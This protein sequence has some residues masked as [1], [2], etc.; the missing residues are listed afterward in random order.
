LR[1]A[2]DYFE[3]L[4]RAYKCGAAKRPAVAARLVAM[5]AKCPRASARDS[6][7]WGIINTGERSHFALRV[8]G[9]W[10][11]RGLYGV[12]FFTKPNVTAAWGVV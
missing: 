5:R 9:R 7:A 2:Y 3:M 1:K 11:A 10:Y 8:D 4:P 12:V 6:L